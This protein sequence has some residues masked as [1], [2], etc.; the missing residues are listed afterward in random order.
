MRGHSPHGIKFRRFRFHTAVPLVCAKNS[1]M[2]F[3]DAGKMTAATKDYKNACAVFAGG[4]EIMQKSKVLDNM[5]GHLT[6]GEREARGERERM[7]SRREVRLIMPEYLDGDGAAVWEK[8]VS[9][10]AELKLFD[11]LDTET[12]G[13]YC[14][15]T[16]RILTLRRKYSS[17]LRG[18]RKNS[19]LLDISKELRLL[20]SLQLS[21]ATRLG[22]TPESRARLAASMPSSADEDSADDLYG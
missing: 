21:Y 2:N 15:V 20:E 9:D 6:V 4:K 17:C 8:L 3:F 1:G 10:A 14:S 18:H 13:S 7:M 22:L 5:T 12:L 16:S 19:E 11:D